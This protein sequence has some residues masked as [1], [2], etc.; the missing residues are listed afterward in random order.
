MINVIQQIV[1]RRL[2]AV[3]PAV[4]SIPTIRGG[5]KENLIAERV[6]LGGTIRT[7]G[8]AARQH[9]IDELERALNVARALGA[10]CELHVFKGMQLP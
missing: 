1:S 5:V 3:S 6:E 4:V 2:S 9:I 10:T 8:G 7:T